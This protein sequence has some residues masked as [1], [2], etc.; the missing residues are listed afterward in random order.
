[1]ITIIHDNSEN[2]DFQKLVNLLDDELNSRYGTFQVQYDKYNKINTLDSVVIGYLDDEAVG[3]GCFR[4]LDKDTIEI[5]RMIVK[6]EFRGRGIGKII[7]QG[8]EKW[9]IEKGHSRSILETG[10][11]QIEAIK[12]YTKQGYKKIDNYGQYIGNSNSICMSKELKR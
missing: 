6:T 9:A 11:K 4:I 12:L 10:K 8:L 1:M 5:K 3:C 7:L 2:K